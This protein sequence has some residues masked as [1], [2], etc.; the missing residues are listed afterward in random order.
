M[1]EIICEVVKISRV[2]LQ[3]WEPPK[4][5]AGVEVKSS[6]TTTLSAPEPWA[7]ELFG[8]SPVTSAGAAVTSRNASRCAP[9][10]AAVLVISEALGTL[11]VAAYQ[12]NG[13]GTNERAIDHPIEPLLQVAAS[14]YLSASEFRRQMTSDALLYGSGFAKIIRVNGRPVDLIR[15]TPGAGASVTVDTLTG[16]P[17][18]SINGRSEDLR[19]IFHLRAPAVV[20]THMPESP[21]TQCREAIGVYL[22]MERHAG[23][24]FGNGARPSGTLNAPDKLD[25][26]AAKRMKGSWDASF[27][28]SGTNRGGTAILEQGLK[29]EQLSLSS[30]DAQ[31]LELRRF[32]ISEIARA[33]RVPPHMLYDLERGTWAN[34]Q[35]LGIEFVAYTLAP[36]LTRWQ[37]EIALKLFTREERA[38]HSVRFDTD[39]FLKA[40]MAVF[41]QAMTQLI[42]ARVLNPN[43]ARAKMNLAPYPSGDKF[44]NPNTLS[45]TDNPKIPGVKVDNAA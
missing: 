31:F 42:A 8:G 19:D 43:E 37:D 33:F 18:Y 35:Y 1:H 40:D 16:E 15:L 22:A 34:V 24:L 26:A 30:V 39:E 25:P 10:R 38:T 17:R 20:H 2:S 29:F 14:D 23:D 13:D 32:Q 44:E 11:P 28:N 36:W 4:S 12:R 6:D 7:Y 45:P 27:G 5:L 21:V 3:F 9:V 41:A